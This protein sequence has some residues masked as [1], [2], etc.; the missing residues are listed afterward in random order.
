MIG[1]QSFSMNQLQEK[2]VTKAFHPKM[3]TCNLNKNLD[4]FSF[5]L[6]F[7]A[8]IFSFGLTL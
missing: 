6:N 5:Y 2:G 3:M 4:R 7:C 8:F 1:S